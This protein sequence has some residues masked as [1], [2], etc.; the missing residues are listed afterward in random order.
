[1]SK[2][3]NN[4]LFKIILTA[5]FIAINIMLERSPAL[6]AVSSHVSLSVIT[7]GFAAVY[8]GVTYTVSIAALGDLLGALLFPF[9]AYNPLFTLTNA[10]G[11]LITALFLNKK[12]SVINIS[13]SVVLNK[14]VCTLLLNS[15]FIA[16]FYMGGGKAFL[17]TFIGRLPQ[18][19]IMCVTE[20][21]ILMLLFWIKSPVRKRI[22]RA[23]K[24]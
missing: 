4:E 3:Q 10:I 12:A 18:A 20:I 21:A 17:P 22:D 9:G 11:G 15:Y 16:L 13:L 23:I 14:A 19:G 6:K 7:I 2:K 24:I 1:M 8:L 5:V